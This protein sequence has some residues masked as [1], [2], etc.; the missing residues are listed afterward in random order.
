MD[1]TP[2]GAAVVV[3]VDA[4]YINFSAHGIVTFRV[5]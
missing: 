2:G 5:T 3:A 1:K 4:I